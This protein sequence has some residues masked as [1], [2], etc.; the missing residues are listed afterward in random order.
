M[1][2]ETKVILTSI[3]THMKTSA[4]L[5]EAIVKV[6]SMCEKDWILA[7]NEAADKIKVKIEGKN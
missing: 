7:A 1:S 3:L 4:D 6:E 2:M 5:D